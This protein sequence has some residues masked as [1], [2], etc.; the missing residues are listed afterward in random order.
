MKFQ[1][2]NTSKITIQGPKT[3][4]FGSLDPKGIGGWAI[5]PCSLGPRTRRVLE[6]K[7]Q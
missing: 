1:G 5:K 2:P 7:H 3:L 6:G 4:L